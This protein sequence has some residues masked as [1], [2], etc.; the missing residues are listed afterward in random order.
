[1]THGSKNPN[2]T[3][4]INGAVFD[5]GLRICALHACSAGFGRADEAVEMNPPGTR[6]G[7]RIIQGNFERIIVTADVLEEAAN[8][9]GHVP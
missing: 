5:T 2:L 9:S 4:L 7:R 1:M 6:E 8:R 3:N